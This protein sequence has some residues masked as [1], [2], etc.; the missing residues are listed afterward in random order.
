M[1]DFPARLSLSSSITSKPQEI[2][3]QA[4]VE[5]TRT[6]KAPHTAHAET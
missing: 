2:R 4:M 3:D 6:P 1:T 5:M